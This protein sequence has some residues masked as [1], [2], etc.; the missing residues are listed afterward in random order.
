[1]D[2]DKN[3]SKIIQIQNHLFQ[4]PI[5]NLFT[6]YQ[7]GVNGSKQSILRI[8]DQ[9]FYHFGIKTNYVET[10]SDMG[11]VGIYQHTAELLFNYQITV[12]RF[13]TVLTHK[14]VDIIKQC[15][16]FGI[17]SSLIDV[18]LQAM[19]AYLDDMSSKL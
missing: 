6:C 2:T 3:W 17:D 11:I 10:M 14:S 8:F 18:D 5:V 12:K 9:T 1:M 16:N 7:L 4:Y 13:M 15:I 19:R